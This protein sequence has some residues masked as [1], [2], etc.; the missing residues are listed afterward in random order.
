MGRYTRKVASAIKLTGQVGK[1]TKEF[2]YE[3]TFS[4][5]TDDGREFVEHLWARRKVGYLLDQIRINGEKKELKDE[6]VALARKYGITTPY[7][8]W[9]IVPD[10]PVPTNGRRPVTHAGGF[11]GGRLADATAAPAGP[12]GPRSAARRG[13]TDR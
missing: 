11:G 3:H 9:L 1:E 13:G 6:V 5:K 10:A 12:K 4:E 7:T 2:V 8:S